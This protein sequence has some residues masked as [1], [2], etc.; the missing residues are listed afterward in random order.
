MPVSAGGSEVGRSETRCA[1]SR[2]SPPHGGTRCPLT[3]VHDTSFISVRQIRSC[4]V[5]FPPA[6]IR[7][8]SFCKQP[9]RKQ[10]S[11]APGTPSEIRCLPVEPGDLLRTRPSTPTTWG[12]FANRPTTSY[13]STSSATSLQTRGTPVLHRIHCAP[14][15]GC[16]L[17]SIRLRSREAA[18]GS[19]AGQW[20]EPLRLPNPERA[21]AV[22]SFGRNVASRVAHVISAAYSR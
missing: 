17:D 5:A 12:R 21:Y 7:D 3:S 15:G 2:G 22:S 19:V 1:A 20:S 16:P 14:T 13:R 10:P 4:H 6:D 18:D 11:M 8:W 9:T